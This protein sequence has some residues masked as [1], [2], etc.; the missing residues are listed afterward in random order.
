MA[1]SVTSTEEPSGGAINRIV[2]GRGGAFALLVGAPAAVINGFLADQDPKPKAALNA[3]LVALLAAF[4]I[5]GFVASREATIRR[6]LHGV[7]AGITTFALVEVIG[8]IG[9]LDRGTPVSVGSIIVLGVMAIALSTGG[10]GVGRRA[11]PRHPQG[12]TPTPGGSS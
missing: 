12:S 10:A 6:P 1:R 2:V 7:L 8:V 5:A 4:W 11:E 3:T 9:R